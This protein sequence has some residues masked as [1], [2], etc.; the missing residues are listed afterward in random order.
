MDLEFELF[1]AKPQFP[2]SKI[3]FHVDKYYDYYC[4]YRPYCMLGEYQ[5]CCI[6]EAGTNNIWLFW[7]RTIYL[8]SKFI[9]IFSTMFF[10]YSDCELILQH[11][12][13]F[14]ILLINEFLIIIL[15]WFWMCV[16]PFGSWANYLSVYS[17][18]YVN[19]EYHY[20]LWVESEWNQ[21]NNNHFYR[22]ITRI[23]SP[24]VAFHYTQLAESAVHKKVRQ[25]GWHVTQTVWI[26]HIIIMSQNSLCNRTLAFI[27]LIS[28]VF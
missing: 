23:S 6:L 20:E 2:R 7:F 18:F 8:W 27:L 16:K 24:S 4:C 14:S 11:I 26:V 9:V 13:L 3:N 1:F 12:L 15:L 5:L 25:V 22:L 19:S 17:M 21:K 10:S 28:F